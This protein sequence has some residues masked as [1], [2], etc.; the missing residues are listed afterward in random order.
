MSDFRPFDRRR[1]PRKRGNLNA[2]IHRTK[3]MIE[4]SLDKTFRRKALTT[5]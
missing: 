1:R 2:I 5:I 3:R 4:V